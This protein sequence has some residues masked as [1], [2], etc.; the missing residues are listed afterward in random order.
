MKK[1]IEREVEVKFKK[2]S[3][4]YAF[5]VAPYF[6]IVATFA[7]IVFFAAPQTDDFCTFSRLRDM[8]K[9]N[10]LLE[11]W[12]LYL[13]WTGRYSA[14]FFTALSGYFVNTF[15]EYSLFVYSAVLLIFIFSLAFSCFGFV[16]Q[17]VYGRSGSLLFGVICL[18]VILSQMP[19][20]LEG[21]FWVTGAAA[22]TIGLATFL[23]LLQSIQRDS[24]AAD[25]NVSFSV[26]TLLLIFVTVGVNEFIALG[27]GM[28]LCLRIIFFAHSRNYFK[29][30]LVYLSVFLVGF[31]LTVF[32]PGNFVRDATID[33]PRHDF[34][35]AIKISLNDLLAFSSGYILPSI[36]VLVALVVAAFSAGWYFSREAR[37]FKELGAVALT[38]FG[39]FPI[40]LVLYAFLT[41]EP[42]PGRILNQAYALFLLGLLVSALWCGAKF[43]THYKISAPPYSALIL[44]SVAGI[45]LGATDGFRNVAVTGL[46]FGPIWRAEQV[47]RDAGLRELSHLH[48]QSKLPHSHAE[49]RAFTMEQSSLPVL[50]GADVTRERSNWINL[51]VAHYYKVDSV[52]LMR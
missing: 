39:M 2:Y 5:S 27:V 1:L 11:S 28:F 41:G 45:V 17:A 30:N 49:V 37:S 23:L 3:L 32:S 12:H 29:Q 38:L 44:I 51:C 8:S 36:T 16:S 40:H 48:E 31:C 10:P 21:I 43:K 7:C 24:N 13:G 25:G 6:L 14:I 15:S 22:Y 33:R 4:L 52:E 42:I 9:N 18:A 47:E 26:R 34:L 20:P 35:S 46:N 19:S 50:R